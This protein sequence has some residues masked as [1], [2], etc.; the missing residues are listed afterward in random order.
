MRRSAANAPMRHGRDDDADRR[1]Q[2]SRERERREREGVESLTGGADL[3]AEARARRVGPPGPGRGGE[4]RGRDAGW[5]RIG[6]AEGGGFFSFSFSDFY[7]FSF[8]FLLLFLFISFP[9]NQ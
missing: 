6:P 1:A 3:S 8:P 2:A 5:A 4:E 7:F 9:L